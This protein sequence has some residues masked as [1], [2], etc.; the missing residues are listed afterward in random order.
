MLFG[1]SALLS[2]S[3]SHTIPP[4]DRL[5]ES[6][7]SLPRHHLWYSSVTAARAAG[8]RTGLRPSPDCARFTR[9][10]LGLIRYHPSGVNDLF[11]IFGNT[12][13]GR[14]HKR[15]LSLSEKPPFIASPPIAFG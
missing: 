8:E 7:H 11:A 13:R 15:W 5:A 6:P 3:T 2:T 14:S 4:A 1:S 12:A 10:C 9:S